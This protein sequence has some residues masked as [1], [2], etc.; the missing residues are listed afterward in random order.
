MHSISNFVLIPIME[1]I[2]CKIARNF[3]ENCVYLWILC[4]GVTFSVLVKRI[5][6]KYKSSEVAKIIILVSFV[7]MEANGADDVG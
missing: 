5:H 7:R 2:T 3:D 4:L 1:S 6:M